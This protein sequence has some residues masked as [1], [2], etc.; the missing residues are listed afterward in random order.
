MVKDWPKGRVHVMQTS[1]SPFFAAPDALAD[2]LT[3]IEKDL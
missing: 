1:H 3:Q 2:L